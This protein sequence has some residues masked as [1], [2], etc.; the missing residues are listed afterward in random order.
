MEIRRE[1]LLLACLAAAAVSLDF[2]FPGAPADDLQTSVDAARTLIRQGRIND[3]LENLSNIEKNSANDPEAK[4]ALG[5][6]F[7]EL[8]ALRAEQL[9]RVAPDSLAAHELLGKWLESQAK[10][11]EALAQ[12]RSALEKSPNTPG[13]HF[14]IGN[15]NWKLGNFDAAEAALQ[16][17][18]KLNPHHAMANL[19]MGEILLQTDREDPMKAVACLREATSDAQSSLEAHRELGKAL[20]LAHKYPEALK[21]LQL[22]ESLAPDD[23]S[24][25]A[26]LAALYKDI[27]NQQAAR[28]EIEL[29][30]EILRSKQEASRKARASKQLAVQ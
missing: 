30:A 28:K 10:L 11:P 8:A 24:V 3:A 29:H 7:Q 25:H 2:R 27:G 6:I 4:L 17:E 22:V 26:Q 9:Q 13:L 5:E 1:V 12:Y 14:L 18:L 15:V 16:D 19:R 21:E 20:R 23:D